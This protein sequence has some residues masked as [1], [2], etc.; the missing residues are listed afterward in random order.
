MSGTSTGTRLMV[1]S[2]TRPTLGE[3]TRQPAI[4]QESYCQSLYDTCHPQKVRGVS[5]RLLWLE[6]ASA[7]A[8]ALR[9]GKCA[10]AWES[11]VSACR[12]VSVLF[13]PVFLPDSSANPI[14]L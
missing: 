8:Y 6:R 13:S 14:L 3:A 4:Q 11:P 5:L 12:R 7:R 10:A 1:D 2:K 9:V